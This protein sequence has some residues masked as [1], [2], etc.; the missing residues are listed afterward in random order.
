MKQFAV[1]IFNHYE[2]TNNIQIISAESLDEAWKQMYCKYFQI[3]IPEEMSRQEIID[4]FF[5]CEQVVDI[6][7]IPDAI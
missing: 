1:A 2:N 3:I 4:S 5:D 7:E 6:L